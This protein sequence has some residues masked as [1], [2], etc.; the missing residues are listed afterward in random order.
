M[1][2]KIQTSEENLWTLEEVAAFLK[3][4][5][6]TVRALTDR[7]ELGCYRIGGRK[8]RRFS[9]A[10]ILA[11]LEKRRAL[12][13]QY[14][15]S[16]EGPLRQVREPA[17][18]S[19]LST[20]AVLNRGLVIHDWYLLPESFSEPLVVEAIERFDVDVGDT[21]L[22][23]FLGAGTTAVT[24]MLRG[25]NVLG[26]E[27]NPFLCF[28]AEVKTDWSVDVADFRITA[29]RLLDE[30]YPLL[31]GLSVG[32]T[33]FSKTLSPEDRERA[34]AILSEAD[35]P[36][37]P[38]LNKWMS[39]AVLQKVL[40]LRYL[41]EHKVSASLQRY[42]LL[43]LAAILRPASNM[44]LAPHA[45]GSSTTKEDAPVF[46]LFSQ[47]V[48]KMVR[49][50]EYVQS[51]RHRLGTA[52]VVCG[53]A[54]RSDRISAR[55]HG[56]VSLPAAL[57]ITSPPYLNNLDYT[58]QT[59][60]ELFFLRFVNTMAEL[61]AI[62]RKML[63]CDAKAMY[64]DIRDSEEVADVRTIQEI[65]AKLREAHRGKRWGWDYSFMTTQYFGGMLKVLR[66]VKPLLRRRGRFILVVGESAHSGI[67]VPVPDILAELGE[68]VGYQLEEI[69][70]LRRRRSSSHPYE[71]REAEVILRK[72]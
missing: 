28:A 8:E 53:D 57:A 42:F 27:V 44:K 63:I 36:Q 40:V 30:A 39:Q 10:D 24:G 34:E 41:I 62:R 33:L 58:M 20:T 45:F 67:R 19:E 15:D 12:P 60:M 4:S 9:K 38:R 54:R 69:N 50:L 3:V 18:L 29:E 70:V 51:L 32:K 61:R 52:E 5:P 2:H 26:I 43:A 6:N 47:K 72:K 68:R 11:Y 1:V 14:S 71:L 66:S 59:R 21:L 37:M 64:R 23:P 16:M 13:F 48:L 22:D 25:I 7:G 56:R 31:S 55:A 17:A 49:D 35:E 46:D 65:A